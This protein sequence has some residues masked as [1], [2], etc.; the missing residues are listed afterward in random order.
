MIEV[1][2][3]GIF[4]TGADL[5]DSLITTDEERLQ[6][7]YKARQQQLDFELEVIKTQ[8]EINKAEAQHK[9]IFVAGW[10][11]AIGWVCALAIGY[12]FLIYP[13]ISWVWTLCLA[14]GWVGMQEPPE[15]NTGALWTIVTGMLGM[16]AMRTVDKIKKVDTKTIKPQQAEYEIW[17][18]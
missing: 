3:G 18:D 6:E 1:D 16:G 13:L 7:E 9:S 5:V 17:D 12:Q 4:K 15:I 2:L 8:T 11:P 14:Q 10:R